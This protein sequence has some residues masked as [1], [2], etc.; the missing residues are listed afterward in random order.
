[1][2]SHRTGMVSF[3]EYQMAQALLRQH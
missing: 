2:S 3:F 1:M